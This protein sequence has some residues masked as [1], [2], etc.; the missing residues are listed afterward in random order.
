MIKLKE[1]E[2][3]FSDLKLFDLVEIPHTLHNK[4]WC[5]VVY[6][7]RI[8][9]QH[10]NIIFRGKKER[11]SPERFKATLRADQYCRIYRPYHEE[12]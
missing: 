5:A 1:I 10:F 12:S 4:R 2:G 11:G 8:S 6:K 9:P 7:Q 3:T